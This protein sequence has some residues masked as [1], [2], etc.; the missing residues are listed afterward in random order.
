MKLQHSILLLS[1][2]ASVTSIG[3]QD[4]FIGGNLQ[5]HS[6]GNLAFHGDLEVDASALLHNEA[7]TL[8]TYGSVKGEEHIRLDAN[9]SLHVEGSYSLAHE[10]DE[11]F[12]SLTIGTAGVVEVTPG[13]SLTLSQ[14]LTNLNSNG[15]GLRLLADATG[16]AQLITNNV[17]ENN[18]TEAQQY[19]TASSNVGWR[20][21]GSPVMTTLSE[22]DDDFQTFYQNGPGPTGTSNQWNIYW[23]DA[24]PVGG[25]GGLA[26][27]D[28]SS[29]NA[30][31]WRHAVDNTELMGSG[32]N[33]RAYTIFIGAP[34][35]IMNGGVLDFTGEVGHGS[36]T[37]DV[38][39]THDYIDGSGG[40][41]N[42]QQ[43]TGWNLIPNPYPSNIDVSVLLADNT[44]FDLAYKAVH[45]WDAVS[46]QYTAMTDGITSVV[47]WNSVG[48]PIANTNNIAPFQAFWVKGD[49]TSPDNGMA[50]EDITL[51]DAHRTIDDTY[52]V[53]KQAPPMIALRTWDDNDVARD[54]AI[55]AIERATTIGVDGN[56]AFKLKSTNPNVPSLSLLS[57]M[58]KLSINRVPLP[59]PSHAL[60]V[61][62]ESN[63]DGETYHIGIAEEDI[64]LNWTIQLEDK[65]LGVFTNLRT[66]Q[67]TFTYDEN[68][69][70]ARFVVHINRNGVD[71]DEQSQ[72]FIEVF[73][74]DNE[75]NVRFN[76]VDSPVAQVRV[77]SLSGQIL[78]NREVST[79]SN[80]VL[81][82]QV[83][84][85]T[86]VVSVITES[87]SLHERVILGSK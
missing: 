54:Q 83:A 51:T 40:S 8:Y 77:V 4:A 22:I 30:N 71:V 24:S 53:F 35:G 36:Y 82:L 50:S 79:S 15:V 86:Y 20:Q 34:F 78:Y 26:A 46:Q 43:I 2:I 47:N 80:L 61:S 33:A 19:L 81:P 1:L 68:Y 76:N 11:E 10:Q 9:S 70:D 66:G 87:T 6:G 18:P 38:Y 7:G 12:E 65:K 59:V 84:R 17:V 28:G 45:V 25:A 23:Y 5:L 73:G 14:D 27:G 85:S 52:N 29:A 31:H 75:V 13:N 37:F 55:I 64:D 16:Y 57:G 32:N 74:I 42:H 58:S 48:G 44:N 62:F 67:Y 56:D 69:P 72:E 60:P 3:Q 41:T 49:Y 63:K 39:R 21:I